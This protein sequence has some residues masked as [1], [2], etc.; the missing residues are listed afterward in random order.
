M[1]LIIEI[2]LNLI[3][4]VFSLFFPNEEMREERKLKKAYNKRL[5]EEKKERERKNN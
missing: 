5:K 3:F 1:S 2:L 4:S